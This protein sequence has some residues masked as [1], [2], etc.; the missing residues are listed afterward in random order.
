MRYIGAAQ[1][2]VTADTDREP[3]DAELDVIE[4]EIPLILAEVDLLD[5]QITTLDRVPSEV[6]TR[7]LRRARNRVLTLRPDL[8]NSTSTASLSRGAAC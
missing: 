6:D 8:A 5:V 1:A 2:G 3:S 7:R 4:R